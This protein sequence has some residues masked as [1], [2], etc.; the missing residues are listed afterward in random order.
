MT[1]EENI[2]VLKTKI[3]DLYLMNKEYELIMQISESFIEFKLSPKNLL[4]FTI[5]K[6]DLIT[7]YK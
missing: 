4:Q 5:T 7:D 1:T 6:K 3:H 2:K